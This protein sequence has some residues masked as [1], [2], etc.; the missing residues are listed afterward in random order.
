MYNQFTPF[1]QMP[2]FGQARPQQENQLIRVTGIEGA[3]SYQMPYANST[4][5]LFDSE[6]DLMYVK[7]TDGAGFPT[8]RT[9]RF[10]A[11]NNSDPQS[12]QFASRTELEELRKEITDVK[13]L[14]QRAKQEAKSK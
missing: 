11:V 13:Q 10:D 1:P 4:V 14:I 6:E 12:E 2:Q 9:F 7:S 8:I 3:K 5:A